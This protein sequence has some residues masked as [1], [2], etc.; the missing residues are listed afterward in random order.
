MWHGKIKNKNNFKYKAGAYMSRLWSQFLEQLRILGNHSGCHQLPERSF[1]YKGKQ[2][3][4]CARCTGVCIG[5]FLTVITCLFGLR[6]KTS[7]CLKLIFIMGFDWLIQAIK[8]KKS[9]NLRRLV[10]GILGGFG[11][12]FFYFNILRFFFY[13]IFKK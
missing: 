3:P 10:S 8:I 13:H 9:T 5:E 4:V 1:F 2:F 11:L 12:F 7:T 6:I